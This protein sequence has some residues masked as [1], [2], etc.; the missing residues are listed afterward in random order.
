MKK[1]CAIMIFVLIVSV[2]VL[3][4]P[5]DNSNGEKVNAIVDPSVVDNFNQFNAA[6]SEIMSKLASDEK[7]YIWTANSNIKAGGR[8]EAFLKGAVM[9]IND[10]F[11]INTQF[12]VPAGKALVFQVPVKNVG[13]TGSI[14]VNAALINSGNW[15]EAN[16]PI[17][18]G[19]KGIVVTDTANWGIVGFTLV[20][21]GTKGTEYK[22]RLFFGVPEGTLA[23]QA[24]AINLSESGIPQAFVAIEQPYRIKLKSDYYD[25]LAPGES[26]KLTCEVWNQIN[27]RGT[28]DQN[29]VNWYVTDEDRT[30]KID[31]KN[32]FS[33][34]QTDEAMILTVGNTAPT[35]SYSVVA[36]SIENPN[37]RYGVDFK[38]AS[39]IPEIEPSQKEEPKEQ[40]KEEIKEET[41]IVKKAFRDVHGVNHWAKDYVDYVCEKGLMNGTDDN[42]FSPSG[43]LTRGMLVTVLYRIDG[44]PEISGDNPF[45]DVADTAYYAKAVAWAYKNGIVNGTSESEFSPDANITREQI[46]SII[47]R[48]AKLRSY[49]LSASADLSVYKDCKDVSSYAT[50]AMKYAAGAGIIGG[51]TPDTINPKDSATRAEAAAIIQRFCK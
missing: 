24:I 17:E 26:I 11:G 22:P 34:E 21:P 30:K 38:V 49:D 27:S 15:G 25:A 20:M 4:A 2:A 14:T 39:S 45:K 47:Y 32:A 46:A 16:T 40:P 23:G 29:A 19:D 10:E 1:I 50:E 43:T 12:M 31:I 51:K 5:Y 9:R 41:V 28:L 8:Y 3:A 13:N 42:N 44:S 18:C 7:S 6:S 48:Y 36:E 33:F 35:G 37:V